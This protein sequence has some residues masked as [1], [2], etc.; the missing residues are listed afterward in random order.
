MNILSS[1]LTVKKYIK[2][3]VNQ[4]SQQVKFPHQLR[5]PSKHPISQFV[6]GFQQ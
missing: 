1:S 6:I 4:V 2:P 3:T 5:I